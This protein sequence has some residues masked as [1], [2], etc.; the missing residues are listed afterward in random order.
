MFIFLSLVQ[1]V[2][3]TEG[4]LLISE[5]SNSAQS[6]DASTATPLIELS[7]DAQ[8]TEPPIAPSTDASNATI[9]N[10]IKDDK[11]KL[12]QRKGSIDEKTDAIIEEE[13]FFDDDSEDMASEYEENLKENLEKIIIDDV[14]KYCDSI[15]PSIS[16]ELTEESAFLSSEAELNDM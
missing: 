12:A 1:Y 5:V 9:E 3:A 8:I 11:L 10:P 14:A 15:L 6:T 4:E 2:L 13:E 16:D 7:G